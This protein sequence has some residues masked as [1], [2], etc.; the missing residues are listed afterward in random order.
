MVASGVQ[1]DTIAKVV[2][3]SKPTLE[4]YYREELDTATALAN[5][6]VASSLFRKANG[7]GNQSVTAAIFWMKTRGG[8]KEANELRIGNI[9][10]ETFET[11]C[12]TVDARIAARFDPSRQLGGIPEGNKTPK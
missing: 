8:W 4:K 9:E 7:D 11:E 12:E 2:K 5:A 3:I 1:Q 6:K 10:G